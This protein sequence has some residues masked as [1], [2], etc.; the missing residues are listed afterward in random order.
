MGREGVPTCRSS[1]HHLPASQSSGLGVHG[2]MEGGRAGLRHPVSRSLFPPRSYTH[3]RCGP[4]SQTDHPSAPTPD[5]PLPGLRSGRRRGGQGVGLVGSDLLRLLPSAPRRPSPVEGYGP[6]GRSSEGRRGTVCEKGLGSGRDRRRTQDCWSKRPLWVWWFHVGNNALGETGG[7]GRVVKSL[8]VGV[9]RYNVGVG[10]TGTVGPWEGPTRG[11]E[12]STAPQGRGRG[13]TRFLWK[14]R[15]KKRVSWEDSRVIGV[16][17]GSIRVVR[18][19]RGV[20]GRGWSRGGAEG[21]ALWVPTSSGLKGGRK[22]GLG[23]G[24]VRHT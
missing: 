13:F 6:L 4:V 18:V 17:S 9:R 11:L 20:E 14:R 5:L 19:G 10:R 2:C 15:R 8:R 16:E 21:T 12:V 24:A 7:V 23:N 22:V 3:D 1:D